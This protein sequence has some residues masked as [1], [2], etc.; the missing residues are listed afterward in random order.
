MVRVRAGDRGRAVVLIPRAGDR[1]RAVVLI[2]RPGPPGSLPPVP[3]PHLT[4]P[5]SPHDPI[6]LTPTPRRSSSHG[7]RKGKNDYMNGSKGKMKSGL[8][9][10]YGGGAWDKGDHTGYGG[11]NSQ[12]RGGARGRSSRPELTLGLGSLQ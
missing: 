12:H 6:T 4:S 10:G 1:G 3:L 9:K 5:T 7:S 11:S 2:P 8:Y